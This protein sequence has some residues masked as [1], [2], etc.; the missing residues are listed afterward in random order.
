LRAPEAVATALLC[1]GQSDLEEVSMRLHKIMVPLDGSA[2]AEAALDTAV[3]LVSLK[4]G[5][6]LVLMRSADAP[7]FP[8]SEPRVQQDRVIREAEDYLGQVAARLEERGVERVQTTVWYG[9]A[10]PAIVEAAE[11]E[12]VDLIVMSSHG[13]SGFRRLILGSVAECVLRGTTTP[14][15]LVREQGA[16]VSR[17]MGSVEVRSTL[18]PARGDALRYRC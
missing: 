14:I 4:P 16:P 8:G 9:P 12:T 11:N 6:V 10:A 5:A 15:L 3:E 1:G 2:I 7:P 13:R 18:R 17:P